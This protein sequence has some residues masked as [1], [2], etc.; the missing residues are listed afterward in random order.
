M[1]T[2]NQNNILSKGLWG[3]SKMNIL[4]V[5][6]LGFR[7]K[8]FF[9]YTEASKVGVALS[10]T[11]PYQFRILSVSNQSA[12]WGK[13]EITQP[14]RLLCRLSVSSHPLSYG[15]FQKQ[16]L[17]LSVSIPISFEA[18]HFRGPGVF[19]GKMTQL[20][21]QKQRLENFKRSLTADTP[22]NWTKISVILHIKH[23]YRNV[24]KLCKT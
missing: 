20:F 9:L 7:L 10:V 12:G 17:T 8:N 4:K 3:S 24:R 1:N 16:I 11:W 13:Q 14:F 19:W 22:G 6:L 2:L 18:S 21:C 15:S 5:F 23:I